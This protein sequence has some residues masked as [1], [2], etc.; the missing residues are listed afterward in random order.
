MVRKLFY[1]SVVALSLFATVA[2]GGDDDKDDGEPTSAPAGDSGAPVGITPTKTS[3]DAKPTPRPL[4]AD[5]EALAVVA[6]GKDDYVPKVSDFKGLPT[7]TVGS[8]TGVTLATLV[9]KSGAATPMFVAIEGNT[10]N[11]RFTGVARYTYAE[12]ADS[13]ILVIDDSGHIHMA[14]SS[15]PAEEWLIFITSIA[16]S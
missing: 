7:K 1:A 14:S 8:E 16:F 6:P 4:A 11:N 10:Q 5:A 12:V 13:T 9:E 15:I 2:C 3:P